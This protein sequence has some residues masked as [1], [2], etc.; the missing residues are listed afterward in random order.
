MQKDFFNKKDFKRKIL[1]KEKM[2]LHLNAISGSFEVNELFSYI[3]KFYIKYNSYPCVLNHADQEFKRRRRH[4][5]RR[6]WPVFK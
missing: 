6:K 3:D 1:K 5:I 2:I 4:A